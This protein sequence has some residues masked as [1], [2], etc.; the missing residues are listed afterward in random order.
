M[1]KE[2]LLITGAS[3]SLGTA[4][5]QTAEGRLLLTPSHQEFDI[6]NY[7]AC[8]EFAHGQ[9]F[10]VII[11]T[12]A[13]T[14]WETC[15]INPEVAFRVN[16]FGT[17]NMARIAKEKGVP[18]VVIGTDGVFDGKGKVGGYTESDPPHLPV[19]VYGVTKLAGEHLV[20]QVVQPDYLIART[21]WLFGP[22]PKKDQKFVGAMVRQIAQGKHI[23]KAVYDKTGS[24]SYAMHVARKVY[25]L[26]DRGTFGVRHVV[27]TGEAT[28]LDVT[29]EIVR[30]WGSGIKIEGVSSTIFPT[31]VRR[32]DNVFMSTDYDDARLPSWQEALFEYHQMHPH[33]Y[34]FNQTQ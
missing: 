11:H 23:L 17:L 8:K 4:F 3:G 15:H 27:N 26:I 24:P 29:E 1:S 5:Q 18:I 12:A 34:D 7:D 2:Q 14:N 16:T 6:T 13:M 25:E 31:P 32:P 28:R 30:L 21:G 20:M 33:P 9:V 19:S 22:N 10:D